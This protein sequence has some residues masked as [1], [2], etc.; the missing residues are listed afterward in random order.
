[1][2]LLDLLLRRGTMIEVKYIRPDLTDAVVYQ[3]VVTVTEDYATEAEIRN[4]FD[5]EMVL[6]LTK[7]S[8]S[9]NQIKSALTKAEPH[10]GERGYLA[11]CNFYFAIWHFG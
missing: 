11:Q 3:G 2:C 1:M 10:S 8:Y 4:K 5:S 9:Q 7:K 6:S